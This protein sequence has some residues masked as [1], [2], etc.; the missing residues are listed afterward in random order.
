[1]EKQIKITLTT[2]GLRVDLIET[3]RG[4]FFE[5]GNPKPTE[6]GTELLKVLAG[7][8]V[9]LPNKIAIEGHTDSSRSDARITRIGS[10]RPIAP[11]RRE[12][13]WRNPVWMRAASARCADSP[14]SDC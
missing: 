2:E 9:K 12:G 4:L 11:T 3:E 6:A 14:I 10:Y 1:M 5:T 13:F 7:E 8:L